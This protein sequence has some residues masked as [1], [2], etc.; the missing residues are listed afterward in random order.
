M[1]RS[2]FDRIQD[3]AWREIGTRLEDPATASVD[4]EA[5]GSSISAPTPWVG[6]CGALSS[7]RVSSARFRRNSA[8]RN[9]VETVGPVEGRFYA[10]RIRQWDQSWLEHP[11]VESVDRWGD[12]IRWPS[13]L[14]GTTHSFSPTTLRYLATALWL[15]RNGLK[16][17]M[18]I[19]EIGVGFGGLA[20]MNGIVSNAITKLV[21]LP[22]VEDAALVMLEENGL[23][24]HGIS[25]ADTS[26]PADFFISNYAFTE[27]N[28]ELQDFYF[29]Q[30]I[31]PASHGMIISN[32]S[33][34]AESIKGRTDVQLIDWFRSKGI[35]ATVER[36]NELL[37]PG[38]HLSSVT[39]IRW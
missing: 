31:Q 1:R 15:S 21:D 3:R 16:P 4:P 37:G 22:A 24:V 34:F 7:G 36:E 2:I 20:A 10:N 25:R 30:F 28:T 39:M 26:H 27:L 13:L 32:S 11:Q 5:T 35:Q 18:S 17:G 38:D 29:D 23:G 19:T 8:V 14:L 9:I 12:P 6:M 33:I